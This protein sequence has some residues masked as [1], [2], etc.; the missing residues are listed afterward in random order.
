M[1]DSG[2]L[3]LWEKCTTFVIVCVMYCLCA[4]KLHLRSLRCFSTF[5]LNVKTRDHGA[6]KSEYSPLIHL[7]QFTET[8]F[9]CVR[10]PIKQTKICKA[11]PASV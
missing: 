3:T 10:A 5:R 9:F 1:S 6:V 7:F 4:S 2:W 8:F 11:S